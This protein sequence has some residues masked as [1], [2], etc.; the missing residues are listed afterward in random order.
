MSKGY[1]IMA[2]G[3]YAKQAEALALSIK[4]TQSEITSVSVI[5]DREVNNSL[6]DNVIPLPQKDLSM[7]SKWKI[8]NRAYFYDLSPYDETVILDADML[9]LTDISHWWKLFEKYDLLVTD[10]VKTY[11]DEWVEN[12]PYRSAF[13]LNNLPNLYSAFCY[14]KKTEKAKVFFTLIKDIVENWEEWSLRY[15]PE[16]RPDHPSID[17]AMGIAAKVLDYTDITCDLDYPTFTHMKG[18]CQ[19]WKRTNEQWDDILTVYTSHNKIR[20][21]PYYQAGILHYVKKDF[22]T[23]QLLEIFK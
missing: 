9:F 3:N 5:T 22:I 7:N 11:R 10:K 13:V 23:D 12:S 6:F 16:Y 4:S 21:G 1:L 17:V 14:F 20:I 18:R 19:G 8:H 15:T 2:Q